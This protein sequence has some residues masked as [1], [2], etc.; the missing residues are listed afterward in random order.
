MS[1]HPVVISTSELTV[2]T[3]LPAFLGSSCEPMD[4]APV[5]HQTQIRSEHQGTF[6]TLKRLPV[7]LDPMFVIF[8]KCQMLDH[9]HDSPSGHDL[10]INAA[11]FF[12]AEHV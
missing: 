1:V 6:W 7:A 12:Y 5:I 3:F 11:P 4:L 2:F 9:S 8:E 10:H